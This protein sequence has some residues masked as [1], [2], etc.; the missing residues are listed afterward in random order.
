LT[1]SSP[2]ALEQLY[3][4]R[5]DASSDRHAELTLRWNRI[6]NIRLTAAIVLVAGVG[7]A[8]VGATIWPLIPAAVALIS[9]VWLVGRHRSL[10]QERRR[11]GVMRDLNA[12]ALARIARAWRS[13]ALRDDYQPP[14]T[15]PFAADLDLFGR[16]S[17]FHLLDVTETP[18][19]QLALR[20][21]LL[22]PATNGGIRRRQEAVAALAP[23]L[24]W[25]QDLA[26]RG[27]VSRDDRR[28]PEPFLAWAER[29]APVGNLT[30]LVWLTRVST[31][32]LIVFAVANLAGWL[33]LPVWLVFVLINIAAVETRNREARGGLNIVA[34]QHHAIGGYANLLEA[35][36]N[37]P[38]DA[39]LVRTWQ[40]RLRSGDADAPARLR[41]LSRAS[42]WVVPRTALIYFPLQAIFAWD[43]QVMARL[44][45]WR[46]ASGRR[47]RDWLD[48][49]GEA[50]AISALAGLAHDNPSWTFPTIDSNADAFVAT[51]LGHPLLA[52]NVR[53]ANDVQ[54]GPPGSFFLLT[55]SNMSGKSTLLRAIGVNIVLSTAGAPVC[56][57][58]LTLPPVRLW[59]SVHVEDSLEEGVSFFMAELKRL[60]AI[61]DAAESNGTS[62]PRL[63]FLL[64]EILQGTNTAERQIAARQIIRRLVDRGAIGAVSTHDLTL[65]DGPEL[66]EIA[67][68]KH[69]RDTVSNNGEGIQM[70]FDYKLRPGLATS[71]NALKLME[72]VFGPGKD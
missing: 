20:T 8:V 55:G 45:A 71:T 62:E 6:A 40:E 57:E 56:A 25:R 59:T 72:I 24:D 30:R 36:V 22:V 42:A 68:A 67:C 23:E 31:V 50:E 27:R 38:A 61:V 3:Q 58:S 51:A 2:P 16:A 5:R 1:E 47:V 29:G 70:S 17:L 53:I 15:H 64:D 34:Q 9:F 18:M 44:D 26:V 63:L 33:S 46:K 54:V 52:E 13:L 28:D 39:A 37:P 65:V 43:V 41:Q 12:D 32:L 10:G 14:A 7:W 69:L 35:L 21:A 11:A 49:I 66:G 19:G 4:R 60:K 48:V